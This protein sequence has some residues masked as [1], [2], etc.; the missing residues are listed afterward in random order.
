L[1]YNQQVKD[2]VILLSA[3]AD[4][5]PIDR[6]YIDEIELRAHHSISVAKC[7]NDSDLQAVFIN[8]VRR[9][10]DLA[11]TAAEMLTECNID[12]IYLINI[13]RDLIPNPFV[14][15]AEVQENWLQMSKNQICLLLQKIYYD[16]RFDLM[17]EL[18]R[19]L[20]AAG[21]VPHDVIAHC[22]LSSQHFRG[23]W[24]VDLLLQP[25]RDPLQR[26]LRSATIAGDRMREYL[27]S[28]EKNPLTL[29][30]G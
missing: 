5:I 19:L 23:C 18:G 16:Y 15:Q 1:P 2:L 11:Y 28:R 29:Y 7:P 27:L 30:R 3:V 9:G 14:F 12:D 21:H 24:V 6:Q 10:T 8:S 25:E 22:Y 13:L 26:L 20:E 4:L 17:P